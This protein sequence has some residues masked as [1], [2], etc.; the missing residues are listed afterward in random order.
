MTSSNNSGFQ[1]MKF[2]A[3]QVADKV[4]MEI[5]HI[6]FGLIDNNVTS[7][8]VIVMKNENVIYEQ[9][10]DIETLVVGWNE[11]RLNNPVT[12]EAG[13]DLYVGYH[14]TY[15]K[16]VKP[17][18][19]DAGPAVAGYGDLISSSGSNGYWY[20]LMTK[21][22]LDFN[23]VIEAVLKKPDTKMASRAKRA[24]DAVTYNVYCNGKAVATGLE[25]TTYAVAKGAYGR[26]TVTAVTGEVESAESNAIN[27][28]TATGI[29]GVED[30]KAA[31]SGVY[32]IDGKMINENGTTEGLKK[33]LHIVNGKKIITK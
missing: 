26:Y 1:V 10:V 27:Y 9:E 33:G 7:A 6:R 2:D 29:T 14:L 30:A 21:Y 19:G 5:S 22:K 8:S 13:Q 31:V 28:G 23:W 18:A 15:K 24:A 20:S 11:V 17:M 12:I 16:G 4:G 3:S 32:S 25:T